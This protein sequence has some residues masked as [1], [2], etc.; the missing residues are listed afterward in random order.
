MVLMTK[1]RFVVAAAA[2]VLGG[3]AG[4]AMRPVLRIGDNVELNMAASSYALGKNYFVTGQFGLAAHQFHI[5]LTREPRS[6]E[7]LNGLAATYDRLGRFDLSERY[8]EQALDMN[9]V[10]AQTLNNIGYSYL[11]RGKY[12]LAVAFL[13]EASNAEH[14]NAVV[15]ANHQTAVAALTESKPAANAAP[16]LAQAEEPTFRPHIERVRP[17]LQS[18]VTRPETVAYRPV[19]PAPIRRRHSASPPDYPADEAVPIPARRA[20]P[21]VRV[22]RRAAD[23]ASPHD[24]EMVVPPPRAADEPTLP[25]AARAPMQEERPAMVVRRQSSQVTRPVLVALLAPPVNRVRP[26]E[27]TQRDGANAAAQR[28]ARGTHAV[29]DRGTNG[30]GDETKQQALTST[31][32]YGANSN[33]DD[34]ADGGSPVATEP[35]VAILAVA[36]LSRS[37]AG[38]EAPALRRPATFRTMALLAVE[39]GASDHAPALR[40]PATF[41]TMAL[42]AVE[43]SVSDDAPALRRPAPFRTMALLAVEKSVSDDAPALRRPATFRTM[44]LLAVEKSVSDDAPALRRPASDRTMTLMR[45]EN[46]AT[47][48]RTNAG[49]DTASPA[50]DRMTLLTALRLAEPATKRL[51]EDAIGIDDEHTELLMDLG[52]AV[53]R[54]TNGTGRRRM[55]ARMR[56]YLDVIGIDVVRLTNANHYSHFETTVYYR[57]GWRDMA[58]NVSRLLPA[59]VGI[60]LDETMESD[61]QIVL[62]ADLLHFDYHL[63]MAE[64]N[65][66]NGRAG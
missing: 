2:I 12:D 66:D 44:A 63:Q 48:D 53:L 43:K 34:G 21:T 35:A 64:L 29:R 23:P 51:T 52:G 49:A 47:D 20:R 27:P 42:L 46:G 26:H 55:A 58:E 33:R 16:E 5:A 41:R 57:T 11:L 45:F 1:L 31:L 24:A 36:P 7:V 32:P 56:E 22:A 9:P 38:G 15:V 25:F 28:P 4:D 8:Y 19:A 60:E 39:M 37:A 61:I 14:D 30:V 18:L 10:S 3:C 54:V 65:A 6:V 13:R 50:D 40:R 17:S 59:Q 62:G